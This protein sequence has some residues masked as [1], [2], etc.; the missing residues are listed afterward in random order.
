MSDT[1]TSDSERFVEAV[2]QDISGG[3]GD[4]SDHWPTEPELT[5]GMR[6]GFSLHVN[7]TEV[8]FKAREHFPMLVEI[9]IEDEE[10][11]IGTINTAKAETVA[12]GGVEESLADRVD[13]IRQMPVEEMPNALEKL[14]YRLNPSGRGEP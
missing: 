3:N 14:A 8:F 11:P 6:D 5:S 7:Q 4:W 2:I 1:E 9:Y 12:L 13:R 10:H